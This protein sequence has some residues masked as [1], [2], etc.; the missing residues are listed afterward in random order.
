MPGILANGLIGVF[1]FKNMVQESLASQEVARALMY[2]QVPL[3]WMVVFFSAT[4]GGITGLSVAFVAITFPVLVPVI[5]AMGTPNMRLPLVILAYLSGFT[6][7]LLSPIHLCMILSNEYFG[8]SWLSFYKRLWLSVIVS[9]GGGL[10][11]VWVLGRII[12]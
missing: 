10:S 6:G 2:L 7:T 8:A 9:V 4:L 12:H 3:G 1:V 11:Y 5:E